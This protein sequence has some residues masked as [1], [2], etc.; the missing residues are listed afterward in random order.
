MSYGLFHLPSWS[1]Q[2]IYIL[3]GPCNF[4]YAWSPYISTLSRRGVSLP[5]SVGPDLSYPQS[6]RRNRKALADFTALLDIY[7]T[8]SL[9]ISP[10]GPS[11]IARPKIRR[12]IGFYDIAEVLTD[13]SSVFL[14]LPCLEEQTTLMLTKRIVNPPASS[15][16]Y[17]TKISLQMHA[18]L[19]NSTI[20]HNK[21]RSLLNK[22][23]YTES[24]SSY[25]DFHL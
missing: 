17:R 24:S 2:N 18:V 1:L 7:A 19:W 13:K 12:S 10:I 23:P 5:A 25:T 14:D 21:R 9:A 16:R 15:S 22:I 6:L 20:L 8:W 11:S 4:S 3:A